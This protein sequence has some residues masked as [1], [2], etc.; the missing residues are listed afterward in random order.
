MLFKLAVDKKRQKIVRE[1]R[2]E[3][4]KRSAELPGRASSEWTV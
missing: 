2:E 4:G 3:E 1:K